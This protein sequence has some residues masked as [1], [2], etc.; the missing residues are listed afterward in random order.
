MDQL[1]ESVEKGNADA[2]YI[3]GCMYLAGRGVERNT[4]EALWLLHYAAEQ[5][6]VKAHTFL[7]G[8]NNRVD[9]LR[10]ASGLNTGGWHYMSLVGCSEDYEEDVF[11]T[12]ERLEQQHEAAE[13]GDVKAWNALADLYRADRVA[14]CVAGGDWSDGDLV[15]LKW[16]AKAARRGCAEAQ[17]NLGVMYAESVELGEDEEQNNKRAL[18]WKIRA[19]L[20]GSL[21]AQRNLDLLDDP[22]TGGI[23]AAHH[24]GDYV[25]RLRWGQD[26]S[27]AEHGSV[28][29]KCQLAQVYAIG[30]GGIGRDFT[31]ALK[32]L[33]RAAEQGSSL[34][35]CCLEK[36]FQP[37]TWQSKLQEYRR[38]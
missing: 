8:L 33:L 20:N 27:A 5:G 31:E 24:V 29:A 9:R 13:K 4:H 37:L 23:A 32:W 14:Q 7:S 16:Y 15:A 6:N 25:A 2:Q 30:L 3:L 36:P 10:Q 38:R 28:G 12:L 18:K 35:Q 1:H 17:F 34:A 26:G 11:G 21:E 22:Y 19:A